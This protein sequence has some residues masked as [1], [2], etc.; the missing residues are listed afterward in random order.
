MF[1]FSRTAIAVLGLLAM[2]AT[3]AGPSNSQLQSPAAADALA[4]QVLARSPGLR[5]SQAALQAASQQVIPA[6]SLPDARFT[7]HLAP[8]TLNGFEGP[9]G[10]DRNVSG[11]V[12]VSQDLPW[13]GTLALREVA[14]RHAASAAEQSLHAVQLQLAAL[15]RIGYARWAY[16]SQ[17]L[18]VNAQSTELVDELRRVAEARYAAG[19]A[20]QQDVLQAEVRL[21]QLRRERLRLQR[22]RGDIATETNALLD[23]PA[24]QALPEPEPLPAPRTLPPAQLLIA[25]SVR[26]HPELGQLESRIA[27]ARAD[28]SLAEKAYWPDLRVM[29]GYNGLRPAPDARFTVG[30]SI[31]LPFGQAKR[32]AAVGSARASAD[33]WQAR[34]ADRRAQLRS[35]IQQA[36]DAAG[37]ALAA[38]AVYDD[39]LIP[40]SRESLSAARS[41]YGSGSGSFADII[42]AEQALLGARL[43]LARAHADYFIAIAQLQRWTGSP[44]P[45]ADSTGEPQ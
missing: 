21:A 16:A 20:Q 14:A 6:G 42:V 23:Q 7:A 1:M 3:F 18:R 8:N 5:A 41:V 27:G 32:D 29:A 24:A 22:L 33:A 44:L 40:R 11:I 37:E 45:T 17:A 28:L 10:T 30:A 36:H 26:K 4:Q 2:S 43:D 15:A 25:S 19:L 39:E 38:I 35:Q 31:N 13:P 12:G 9:G 34:L